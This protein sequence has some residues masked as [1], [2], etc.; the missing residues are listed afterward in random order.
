M[1]KKHVFYSLFPVLLLLF[2]IW[3]VHILSWGMDISLIKGGI[4]PRE[5]QG[6]AGILFSPFIHGGLK[7]LFANSVPLLLL[8]WCLYY[9]YREIANQV[10]LTLWIGSGIITWLI[11]REAWQI[12]ASGLIYAL[13]FFLF[14]SGVFRKNTRLSAVALIVTF[15]Y[16]GMLWNMSPI[17]ELVD[18][19]TSWEGHLSGAITGL[20]SAILFRHK[21]PKEDP[22]LE[23][24]PNEEPTEESDSPQHELH[25]HY[26]QEHNGYQKKVHHPDQ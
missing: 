24:D 19:T 3:M 21:G 2:A 20:L 23:E 17:A 1:T 9:F 25:D 8:G 18:P 11:G 10:T 22:I 7:H 16:G 4:L 14:S 5:V 12:G 26:T 15:L 13:A 6:L